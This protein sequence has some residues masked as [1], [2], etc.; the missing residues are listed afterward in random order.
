[1][2]DTGRGV[3]LDEQDKIFIPFFRGR[4]AGR[5]PEGLGLGLPIARELAEAHGGRLEVESSPGKGSSFTL[6]LPAQQ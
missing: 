5:F 1:M 4:H 2:A 3:P 6:W